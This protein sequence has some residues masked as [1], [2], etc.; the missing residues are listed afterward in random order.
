MPT[1]TSFSSSITKETGIITTVI[2][3]TTTFIPAYQTGNLTLFPTTT[4]KPPLTTVFGALPPPPYVSGSPTSTSSPD[5]GSSTNTTLRNCGIVIASIVVLAFIAGLTY[6]RYR[7]GRTKKQEPRPFTPVGEDDGDSER[8]GHS[9]VG[10]VGGNSTIP[11]GSSISLTTLGGHH[12]LHHHH[13]SQVAAS[14]SNV[15][16]RRNSQ[17]IPRALD[18]EGNSRS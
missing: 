10:G 7:S 16:E 5:N 13:Q 6:R 12:H 14:N 11:G 17:P 18:L 15:R 3:G 2:N 8:G 9:G 1:T 4:T